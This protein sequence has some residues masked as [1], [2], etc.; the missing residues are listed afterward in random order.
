MPRQAVGQRRVVDL[1]LMFLEA[2][3]VGVTEHR[4]PVGAKF[5][6]ASDGVEARRHGLVRQSVDQVEIDAGYAGPSQPGRRGSGLLETLHPVDGALDHGIEALHAEA[7][8]VDAAK[9]ERVDHL[10]GERARIDLDGDLG[11]GRHKEGLPQRSHQIHEGLGRHDGRR[12]AAEMDVLDLDAAIDLARHQF[13]FTAQ[14]RGIDRDRV[15]AARPPRCCSR[16]TS[17]SPGRT[18]RADRARWR[19]AAE[20]PSAIRHRCR[21]R[22]RPEKCGAVG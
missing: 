22:S 11:R 8:A 16:N 3:D 4:E 1:A 18:A 2:R 6:A 7:C 17:T 13:D 20:L 5:D 10:A 21:D 9:G 19:R 14:R 12:A 15:V